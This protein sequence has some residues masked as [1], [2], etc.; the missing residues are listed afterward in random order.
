MTED[1]QH[2]IFNMTDELYIWL[3]EIW[4]LHNHSKYQHY[5]EE[6]VGNITPQQI[7]GFSRMEKRRNVYEHRG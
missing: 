1:G 5:F 3:K 6:W 2:T 7:E 4:K